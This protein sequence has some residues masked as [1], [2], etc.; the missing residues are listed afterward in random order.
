MLTTASGWHAT[1]PLAAP[2]AFTDSRY[3]GTARLDLAALERRAQAA[4]A[5]TGL[6]ADQLV[7]AVTPQVT[8]ADGTSFAPTLRLALDRFALKLAD[9][10]KALTATDSTEV[11]R[12]A[13][14]P[15]TLSVLGRT[16]RVAD[17]RVLSE[18]LLLAALLAG[19][20][21][22]VLRRFAPA[23]ESAAIHSRYAQLL[24]PVHPMPAPAGRPV[25][26]VTAFATLVRLAERYGLLVLHWTRSDVETFLVQ[27]DGTTYRYRTGAAVAEPSRDS[28]DASVTI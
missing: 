15:R 14:V 28:A 7:V 22:L 24:V 20:T 9:D 4:A 2:K 18:V 17:G 16:F 1:F 27:D 21:A 25:V 3:D 10:V 5:V 23:S 19:M 8:G 11:R 13:L 12:T 6:P 26:D